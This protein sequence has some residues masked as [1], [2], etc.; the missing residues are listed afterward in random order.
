MSAFAEYDVI[1]FRVYF[2]TTSETVKIGILG[3]STGDTDPLLRTFPGN[4]WANVTVDAETFFDLIVSKMLFPV[5]FNSP[6]SSNH[7][8]VTEVRLGAIVALYELDDATVPEGLYAAEGGTTR[9]E[10]TV[11]EDA[12]DIS[13][14]IKDANEI[15]QTCTV[16][17]STIT[18]DLPVGVYTFEIT[19]SDPRYTGKITGS[20]TVESSIQIV[21]PELP[22]SG[23][24]L[25][26]FTIPQ[27]QIKEN[28]E[29]TDNTAICTAVFQPTYGTETTVSGTFT[30]SSSGTLTITYTYEGALEKVFTVTIGRA[31][32]PENVL[33]DLRNND[34]LADVKTNDTAT[35]VSYHDT[36]KYLV[37]T[38]EGNWKQLKIDFGSDAAPRLSGYQYLKVEV[39]YQ[40]DGASGNV[41][42]WFCAGG[43]KIGTIDTEAGKLR[44]IPHDTWYTVYIPTD[45][46]NN[47]ILAGTSDFLQAGFGLADGGHFPKVQ[48]VRLKGFELVK[49]AETTITFY[50]PAQDGTDDVK[51]EQAGGKLSVTTDETGKTYLNWVGVGGWDKLVIVN[52]YPNYNAFDVYEYVAVEVFYNAPNSTKVDDIGLEVNQ[53][54]TVYIPIDTFY[55]SGA[56]NGNAVGDYLISCGFTN[57][58]HFPGVTEVRIGNIYFTNEN[59]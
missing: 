16:S 28:G 59:A 40:T 49:E 1:S 34:V 50:D 57:G 45:K 22:T 27:A 14:V 43:L 54:V 19:T 30:P 46:L 4:T 41:T 26:E 29:P 15:E 18:A 33:L 13:A 8:N 12:T 2:V 47:N 53:W 44:Q 52:H 24:A 55:S 51:V 5:N 23:T 48:E 20:F 9:V 3:G 42:G 10:I 17:G 32:K 35:S 39:Y 7:A 37:W 38:G 56:V 11:H 36:G 25:E 6:N 58:G 31:V 21:E